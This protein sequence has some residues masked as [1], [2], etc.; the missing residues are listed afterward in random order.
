[1]TTVAPTIVVACALAWWA[2][3]PQQVQS[4]GTLTTTVLF[5]REIVRI[6]NNHC[7]MCH[8]DGAVSF[9]LA[10]YEQT[11]VRRG[12]IRTEAL[13]RHMPPWPAVSGYGQFVND[14][15]LTT[16][17]TQFMIAW[18]EGLGPRNAGNVFLNVPDQQK[19]EEV[20][21]YSHADH[22]QLGQPT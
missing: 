10:T 13:R 4:H 14:N 18:V 6:L 2:S 9:P 21:A 20:R 15:S 17:E 8:D 3:W 1:M 22:W 7:V 12:A 16:R 19:R 5:D 11:W